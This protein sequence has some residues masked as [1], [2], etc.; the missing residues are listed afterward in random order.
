MVCAEPIVSRGVAALIR[1]APDL[2]AAQGDLTDLR[3]THMPYDLMIYDTL[4]LAVDRIELRAALSRH[5]I[6]VLALTRDLRPGLTRIAVDL[7]V[8]GQVSVHA[9]AESLVAAVRQTLARPL[10][11]KLQPTD[12]IDPELDVLTPRERD[13]IELVA[14]GHSNQEIA[15]ALFL[16]INSVK[17]F[18]RSA[19]R[20]IGVTNRAQAVIWAMHHGIGPAPELDALT[21]N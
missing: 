12:V 21:R 6:R 13:V 8:H 19:Y 1:A 17:T 16:T 10:A 18:I 2:D 9:P 3:L 7:G 14:A 20:R 15:A 4:A 5:A 11:Q